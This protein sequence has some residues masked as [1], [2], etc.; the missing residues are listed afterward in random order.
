MGTIAA[1]FNG[2]LGFFDSL[3]GTGSTAVNGFVET[4]STA[5]QDV[6]DTV[7]GSLSGVVNEGV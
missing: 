6:Y 1:I 3:L 5:A 4:G 7:T 2:F